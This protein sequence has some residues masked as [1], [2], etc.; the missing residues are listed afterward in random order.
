MKVSGR[1]R[2]F[3]RTLLFRS[4]EDLDLD[5][6]F[7]YGFFLYSL[8]DSE[9]GFYGLFQFRIDFCNSVHA[10]RLFDGNSRTGDRHIAKRLPTQGT[11]T[12]KNTVIYPYLEQD[13][14]L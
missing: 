9:I 10:F 8:Y 5:D 14:N 2:K 1:E 7:D 12:E 11:T 3:W 13:S 6:S 4:P